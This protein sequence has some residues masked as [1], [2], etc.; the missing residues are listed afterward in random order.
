MIHTLSRKTAEYAVIT[1][2]DSCPYRYKRSLSTNNLV[3]TDDQAYQHRHGSEVRC[4]DPE[5]FDGTN[6]TRRESCNTDAVASILRM[7][8]RLLVLR[9]LDSTYQH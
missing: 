3:I 7:M 9:V 8:V 6:I 5:G 4:D 1:V 2:I